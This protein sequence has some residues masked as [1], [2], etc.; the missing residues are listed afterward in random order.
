LGARAWSQR[1]R[2]PVQELADLAGGLDADGAAACYD[3]ARRF[4]EGGLEVV[5]RGREGGGGGVLEAGV[6]VLVPVAMMRAW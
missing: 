5:E 3:D 6:G 4:G 2:G 1:S